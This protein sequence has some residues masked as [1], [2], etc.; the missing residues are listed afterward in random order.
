[1]R[2]EDTHKVRA[3]DAAAQG[4]AQSV[5]LP[6][7]EDTEDRHPVRRALVSVSNKARLLDLAMGLHTCGVKIVSTGSTAQHIAEAGLPVTPVEQMTRF[8]AC[9]GGR[10]KTLHPHIHMPLLADQ[11]NPEHMRQ[12]QLLNIEAFDLLVSDLY[13]FAKVVASGAPPA[14]CLEQIDIGGSAMLRS[15]AKNHHSVAVVIGPEQYPWALE[16]I[17]LGGFTRDDRQ[18]L[19]TEAFMYSANYDTAVTKWLADLPTSALR[20]RSRYPSVSA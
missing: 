11:R 7:P 3:A 15:A 19:A 1:M 16:Q 8:P 14:D 2:R 6:H 13:P 9:L 18:L 10:V 12:L 17:D 20:V 4:S 5:P